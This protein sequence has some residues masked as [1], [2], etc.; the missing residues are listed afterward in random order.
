MPEKKPPALIAVMRRELAELTED[1]LGMIREKFPG[2]ELRFLRIDP[3]DYKEHADI[4]RERKPAMVLL[5]R[6]RP[7]PSLAMEE[8]FQHCAFTRD[9]LMELEPMQP[10]FRPFRPK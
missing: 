9:G 5:P 3:E 1:E 4:C 6:E 8:G 7:I 2:R 10:S